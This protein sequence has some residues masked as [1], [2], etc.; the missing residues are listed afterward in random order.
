MTLFF[1]DHPEVNGIFNIGT[2]TARSWNDI[3]KSLFAA[4]DKKLKIEYIPMPEAIRDKYQYY[5][6]AD[7]TKLRKAGCR[8]EC[9]SLED[10]V[11]DYVKNFLAKG[12]VLG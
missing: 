3:A 6:C 8:H 5:T 1:L 7:L 12:A 10:A 2:G 9:M 4:A 11:E